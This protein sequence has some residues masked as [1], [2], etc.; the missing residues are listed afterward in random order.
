LMPMPATNFLQGMSVWIPFS[1]RQLHRT[2]ELWK[3]E[4]R[5]EAL[6]ER[7]SNER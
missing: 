6:M 4:R 7:P 5:W 2:R 3:S 1:H